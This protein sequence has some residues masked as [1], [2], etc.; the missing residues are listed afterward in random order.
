MTYYAEAKKS[1]SS[2]HPVPAIAIAA[3]DP[4]TFLPPARTIQSSTEYKPENGILRA[5]E[6]VRQEERI[7]ARLADFA[8]NPDLLDEDEPSPTQDVIAEAT[9]IVRSAATVISPMPK[10][11]VSSFFGEI[12]VSWQYEDSIVRLACFPNRPSILQTG[13]LSVQGSYRSEENPTG[14]MLAER[15]KSLVASNDPEQPISG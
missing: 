8:T 13:L 4:T 2:S 12:N 10:A 9:A 7:I 1:Q 15:L 3:L 5:L 14:L 11:S 6:F